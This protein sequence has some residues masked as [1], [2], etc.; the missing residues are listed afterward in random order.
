M[1]MFIEK[2]KLYVALLRTSSHVRYLYKTLQFQV[3]ALIEEAVTE[4]V[5]RDYTKDFADL[6][7]PGTITPQHILGKA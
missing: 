2:K 3:H 5:D 4:S 6:L 1:T 7:F